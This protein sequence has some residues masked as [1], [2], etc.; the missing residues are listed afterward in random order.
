MF[1]TLF[2]SYGQ[3]GKATGNCHYPEDSFVTE[4]ELAEICPDD[5]TNQYHRNFQHSEVHNSVVSRSA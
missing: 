5:N 3:N 2:N 1:N 4:K